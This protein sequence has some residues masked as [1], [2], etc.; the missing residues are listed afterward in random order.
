MIS[1]PLDRPHVAAAALGA[2]A[3]GETNYAVAR[4]VGCSEATVRRFRAKNEEALERLRAIALEEGERSDAFRC[5]IARL[6]EV[7]AAESGKDAP[8][9]R[10]QCARVYGEYAGIIGGPREVNVAGDL[11]IGS[12][13]IAED[14][15][16]QVVAL[17]VARLDA[18]RNRFGVA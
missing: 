12:L 10:A 18:L 17:D 14:R 9:D 2:L 3:G 8:R 4:A 16:T 11:N 13:T 1:D 15:R 6:L 7:G 5:M